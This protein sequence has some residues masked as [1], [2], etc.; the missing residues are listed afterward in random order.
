MQHFSEWI[1]V[2]I[3]EVTLPAEIVENLT[4]MSYENDT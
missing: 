4:K 2:C 1:I 3:R